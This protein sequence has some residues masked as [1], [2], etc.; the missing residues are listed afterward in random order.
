MAMGNVMG[1]VWIGMDMRLALL[2][3][4]LFPATSPACSREISRVAVSAG[5]YGGDGEPLVKSG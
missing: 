1:C 2:L 4:F 5:H 3:Y